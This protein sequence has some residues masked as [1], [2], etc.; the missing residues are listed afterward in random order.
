MATA[1][2]HGHAALNPPDTATTAEV[3]AAAAAAGLLVVSWTVDDAG[4]LA[5]LAAMGVDVV[6]TDR[7]DRVVPGR[8]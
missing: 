7:P 8:R 3:V 6:I 1:A 4:R 2:A 5:E